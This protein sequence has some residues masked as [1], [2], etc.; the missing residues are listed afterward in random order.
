MMRF[1]FLTQVL[2]AVFHSKP[3]R[4]LYQH[5]C[6]SNHQYIEKHYQIV[7]L[8]QILGLLQVLFCLLPNQLILIVIEEQIWH[9]RRSV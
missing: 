1:P 8:L 9:K 3:F 7:G 6:L 2:E 4:I 5:L